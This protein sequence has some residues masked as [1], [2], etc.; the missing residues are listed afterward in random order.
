MS[1]RKLSTLFGRINQ[2]KQPDES[3]ERNRVDNAT[4]TNYLE[5]DASF[6]SVR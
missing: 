1:R 2:R 3:F 4:L 5:D 6:L